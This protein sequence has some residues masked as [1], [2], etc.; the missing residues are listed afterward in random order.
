MMFS[1]NRILKLEIITTALNFPISITGRLSIIK[2]TSRRIPFTSLGIYL[3]LSTFYTTIP[4]QHS[5]L[6]RDQ[7]GSHHPSFE[8]HLICLAF[9]LF[10]FYPLS[11]Q[12]PIHQ[13]HRRGQ[14]LLQ[15]N[16]LHLA[17]LPNSK[18]RNR[19]TTEAKGLFRKNRL[20]PTTERLFAATAERNKVRETV[21]NIKNRI[22]CEQSFVDYRSV[23][24]YIRVFNSY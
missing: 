7:K 12:M 6:L 21:D 19:N 5:L 18:K 13:K 11:H 14:L 23:F 20:E 10:P 8:K 15:G 1:Q 24:K 3:S 22:I 16:L 9:S 17:L 2:N 4:L